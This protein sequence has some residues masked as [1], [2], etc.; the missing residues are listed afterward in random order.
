MS[1]FCCHQVIP[2]KY[3]KE[4]SSIGGFAPPPPPSPIPASALSTGFACGLTVPVHYK[5]WM[6]FNCPKWSQK[7]SIKFDILIAQQLP[8][9]P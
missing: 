3:L 6:M 8:H 9:M 7:N 4:Y 2:S 5:Y 1:Y